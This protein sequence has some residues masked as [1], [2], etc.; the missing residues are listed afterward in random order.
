MIENVL[1]IPNSRA[2]C[3]FPLPLLTADI[4][5]SKAS[6]AQ[7]ALFRGFL[8]VLGISETKFYTFEKSGYYRPLKVISLM[9]G[10]YFTLSP[11]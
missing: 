3:L 1:F 7:V 2:L 5:A 10:R 11:F 6:G 9:S 8:F 4:A